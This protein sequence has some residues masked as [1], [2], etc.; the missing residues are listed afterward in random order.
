MT[1][2][3]ASSYVCFISIFSH[4]LCNLAALSMLGFAKNGADN[5][6]LLAALNWTCGVAKIDCTA[7]LP[8]KQCYKP[9]TLE[10]HASYAFNSYYHQNTMIIGSCDFS[11]V[12][13]VTTTNP[14]QGMCVYTGSW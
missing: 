6:L 5:D 14:S 4:L 11:G 10:A 2:P 7:L 12:A 3:I 1:F 9:N 8:N 13:T